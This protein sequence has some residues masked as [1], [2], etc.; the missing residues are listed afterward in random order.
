MGLHTLDKVLD[1]IGNAYFKPDWFQ[2]M[3]SYL[4]LQKVASSLCDEKAPL[5][6]CRIW[7][8]YSRATFYKE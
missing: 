1:K 7:L 4:Y 2:M 5:S 8:K 3:A 6:L